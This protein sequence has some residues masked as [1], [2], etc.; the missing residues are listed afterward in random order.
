MVAAAEIR[1]RPPSI[2]LL[3]GGLI[4]GVFWSFL[5]KEKGVILHHRLSSEGWRGAA[6]D[7]WSQAGPSN[8]APRWSITSLLVQLLKGFPDPLVCAAFKP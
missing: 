7:T 4:T 6:Q 2:L 5:P 3:Q 8:R 1:Q